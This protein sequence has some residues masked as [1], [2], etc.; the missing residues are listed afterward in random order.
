MSGFRS[1]FPTVTRWTTDQDLPDIVF[2]PCFTLAAGEFAPACPVGA[3]RR[4]AAPARRGAANVSGPGQAGAA[5]V[6]EAA[7]LA[8]LQVTQLAAE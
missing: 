3:A 5:P 8:L 6:P 7:R 1:R 4:L 2:R